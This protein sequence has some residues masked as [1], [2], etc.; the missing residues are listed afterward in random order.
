MSE[1]RNYAVPVD[2]MKAVNLDECTCT[3]CKLSRERA[4]NKFIRWQSE[5]PPE[6]TRKIK[7]NS[8]VYVELRAVRKAVMD[9]WFVKGAVSKIGSVEFTEGVLNRLTTPPRLVGPAVNAV[10]DILGRHIDIGLTRDE[11]IA[12][13]I[14]AAVRKADS[15]DS[16]S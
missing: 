15:V 4:V 2:E 7:Q 9:Q 5:N 11:S 3:P 6:I 1:A 13:S 8:R 16:K 14:V 12:Q 10:Q